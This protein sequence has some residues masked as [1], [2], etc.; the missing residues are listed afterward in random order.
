MHIVPTLKGSNN[1]RQRCSPSA[2]GNRFE[3]FLGLRSLRS[4][5]PRLYKSGAFRDSELNTLID[6]DRPERLDRLTLRRLDRLRQTLRLISPG[7]K[8]LRRVSNWTTVGTGLLKGGVKM[9]D[10]LIE[11][12]SAGAEFK[13]RRTFFMVSFV[14]VGIVFLSALVFDLYAANIDLGTD[15]FELVE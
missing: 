11:S 2:S 1:E 14:V 15:N 8:F 7:N 9:F 6:T 13:P 10:K 12:N 3:R 4:L 5:H